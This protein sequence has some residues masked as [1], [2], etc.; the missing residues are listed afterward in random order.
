MNQNAE[1]SAVNDA[2]RGQFFRKVWAMITPY[3]RS[4]EKGKAWTLLI[5]VIAPVADQ[6]GDLGVVQHLVQGFLQRP[7]AR[8]TRR[9]SGRLILY[10]CAIAAVA[11]VGAVYRLYLTQM[12][13]I[14][15]RAW[16]TEKHFARWL[17]DKNYYQLEQGG[18]TDNPD[19]RISEDL[20]NFTSN[21]LSLGLGL[22]A[23]YRQPGVVL[24]HPVG[25]V[26]QH[27]SVRLSPFPATCSG[28]C[29]STPWW[30][31]G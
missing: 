2:V 15:W 9:R 27:R 22:T 30:A 13:T 26:G 12:L 5:A 6:R 24:D 18:Y 25:C 21:T 29:W 8:R 4:E 14:R 23:Q 16:L 19:Q 28:A 31:V 3:W 10:F 1:Y 20:N 17:G 7:A 11:I